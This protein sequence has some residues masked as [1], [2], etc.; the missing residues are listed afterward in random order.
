MH[1]RDANDSEWY[2][3]ARLEPIVAPRGA[4]T[5]QAEPLDY[6]TSRPICLMG[7]WLPSR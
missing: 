2:A 6:T 3:K 7:R 4:S 5:V 1:Q